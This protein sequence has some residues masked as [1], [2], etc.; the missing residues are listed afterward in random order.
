MTCDSRRLIPGMTLAVLSERPVPAVSEA[1]ARALA[2]VGLAVHPLGTVAVPG[3][4]P[5]V[6]VTFLQIAAGESR[7]RQQT[8]RQAASGD[9]RE[10]LN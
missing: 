6:Q 3:P 9:A 1:A 5:C 7:P 8:S 2:S 10:R 4:V